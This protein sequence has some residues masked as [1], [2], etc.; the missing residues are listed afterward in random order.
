VAAIVVAVAAPRSA[1]AQACC[2]G[3][4]AVTPGRL[5]LHESMLV[6]V[7]ARVTD[8][9]GSYD[10][11]GTFLTMPAGTSEV[12]LEQDVFGAI[13]VLP[14]GQVALLVPMIE[15]RR[16]V[17]GEDA[18]GGGVGD[19]NLGVRYD[20]V[21]AT[22][23]RHVP[24]IAVLAGVTVPTGTP[25]ESATSTLATDATGIGAYQANLGIAVEKV[26]DRWLVGATGLVAKRTTR[27][28]DGVSEALA[29]QWSGLL[30]VA[31]TL[32]GDT[33]LAVSGSVTSEGEARIDNMS[34]VGTHRRL[35]AISVGGATSITDRVRVQAA[36]TFDPPI[37]SFGE[38]QPV[39]GVGVAGTLIFAWL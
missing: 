27:D 6:G 34:S 33:S 13:R 29:A 7:D 3:A 4:A 18:F 21:Y 20:F 10:P 12:D 16:A 15:T 2:A 8:G 37:G 19:I 17:P 14:R 23:S 1:R 22:E 35:V 39:A 5:A 26:F 11:T 31:Y 38:N 32:S 36:V 24:G 9:Y 25:P 28:V 30:A